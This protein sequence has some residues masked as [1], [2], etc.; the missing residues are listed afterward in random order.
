[1]MLRWKKLFLTVGFLC[2]AGAAIV[3]HTS[4]ATEYELSIY[5]STPLSAWLL[6]SGALAVSLFSITSRNRQV[7]TLSLTLGTATT[8]LV[9]SMFLVRDYRYFG[10]GDALTHLGWTRAIASGALAPVELLYPATHLLGVILHA[11]TG[12]TLERNLSVVT[13]LFALAYVVSTGLLVRR[14]TDNEW[15]LTMGVVSAWLF[16]PVINIGSYMMPFPT[17][18]ALFFTPFVLFALVFFFQR[19]NATPGAGGTRA[20]GLLLILVGAGLILV[21]PQQA[22]NVI[23]VMVAIVVV[24]TFYRRYRSRHSISNHTYALAPTTILVGF[25]AVWLPTHPRAESAATGVASGTLNSLFSSPDAASTISQRSGSLADVGGSVPILIVKMLGVSLVFIL[26]S[27]L[28]VLTFWVLQD[29][30]FDTESFVLYFAAGAVPILLL[31]VA[32]FLSTPTIAF[33][34]IAFALVV[35]TILGAVEL[36]HLFGSLRDRYSNRAVTTATV[37]VLAILFVLSAA[38]IFPSPYIYKPTPHVTTE[39]MAG[40]ES[41]FEYGTPGQDYASLRTGPGRFAN[42][43][44]GV[45]SATNLDTRFTGTGIPE[46]TFAEGNYSETY[47]DSQYLIITGSDYEREVMLYRGLRYQ[48]DGFDR[49]SRTPAVNNVMTTGAV[50]LYTVDEAG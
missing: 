35:V 43:I 27:I 17:T 7:R 13:V 26:L 45:D 19:G 10:A 25:L 31:F 22:L 30:K 40:H 48:K 5:A 20:S 36:S 38:T 14:M 9:V 29:R 16:L 33:R 41:A 49:L 21:H 32:Y 18:Q 42:G 28:A 23:L 39:Q 1:M 37:T 24:Q 34:E 47:P 8:I 46:Q 12:G 50:N 2:L 11:V 6:L 44:Y 3:L 4:P 15:G